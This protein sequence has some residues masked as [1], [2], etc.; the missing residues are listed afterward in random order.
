[1]PSGQTLANAL[2]PCLHFNL[3]LGESC[4]SKDYMEPENGRQWIS[5]NRLVLSALFG[6]CL[7]LVVA[8][9]GNGTKWTTLAVRDGSGDDSW[10]RQ[11]IYSV[12]SG[13]TKLFA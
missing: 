12:D 11:N 13:T 6:R 8:D 1:M 5:G 4:A 3:Q 7:C 2:D 10:H 9:H